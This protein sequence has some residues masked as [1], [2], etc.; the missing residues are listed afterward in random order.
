MSTKRAYNSSRRAAQAA[1]TRADV[2]AAAIACFSESGWSGTTLNAVAERAGVAVETIYGGFGT[3]KQLLREAMEVAVVGDAEPVPLAERPEWVE[4]QRGNRAERV[5]KGI[6]L[7]AE[8]HARSARVWSAILEAARSDA[9]VAAF[10][11]EGEANRAHD[12]ERGLELVLRKPL[13]GLVFDVLFVLFGPEAY[14]VL[15]E[16]R[17]LTRAEYEAVLAETAIKLA[18]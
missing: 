13:D 18:G 2:L 14:L 15:T 11:D 8:I 4:M 7:Q 3:K 5:A 17:G 16:G 12:L 9:D 1:Q 6:A 10:R